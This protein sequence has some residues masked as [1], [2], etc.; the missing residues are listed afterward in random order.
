MSHGEVIKYYSGIS[1]IYERR[2]YTS[3]K[4][5]LLSDS[6]I[7]WY[8]NNLP[9]QQG[10]T[11]EVGCGTGRLTRN[12]RDRAGF[13]VATDGSI[14]MLKLNRESMAGNSSPSPEYLVCDAMQLPFRQRSFD[15]VV[16]ARLYWHILDY[17]RALREALDTSKE[18]SVVLFDFPNSLGPF[19]ILSRLRSNKKDVLT[20]FTTKGEL[21]RLF[22]G[23][24]KMAVYSSAS[25]FLFGA[26]S[27]LLGLAPIR[28]VLRSVE[29][30]PFRFVHSLTYSYFL[31]RIAKPRVQGARIGRAR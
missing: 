4:D 17:P 14:E 28:R 25:P 8:V 29:N 6:Q 3:A 12:M 5:K 27:K 11:L 19:W 10:T 31:I 15:C 20:L 24:G 22:G 21:D 26:P 1:G 13:L 2:R 7:T 16:G 18:K 30:L 23:F 9:G